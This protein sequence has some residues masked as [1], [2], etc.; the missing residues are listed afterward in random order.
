M[1]TLRSVMSDIY[2]VVPIDDLREHSTDSDVVC[3]CKPVED[4]YGV[5]VHNSMDGREKYEIGE[6]KLS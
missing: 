4:E 1:V 3:W 6:R 2:H 5:I